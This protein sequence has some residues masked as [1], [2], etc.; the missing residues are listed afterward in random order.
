[1]SQQVERLSL[2]TL[3]GSQADAIEESAHLLLGAAFLYRQANDLL[4]SGAHAVNGRAQLSSGQHAGRAIRTWERED[5]RSLAPGYDTQ[6]LADQM[7]HLEAEPLG[8]IAGEWD[9]RPERQ[10]INE[11]F[12]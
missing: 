7:A 2:V 4:L 10:R 5:D 11:R 3:E 12:W 1:L 6:E 9:S 8:G